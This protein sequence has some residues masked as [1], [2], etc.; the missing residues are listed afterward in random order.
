[1]G[2]SGR[3]WLRVWS[4]RAEEGERGGLRAVERAGRGRG[5]VV[6]EEG[7]ERKGAGSRV[8]PV[9]HMPPLDPEASQP[10]VHL[11]REGAGP[12]INTKGAGPPH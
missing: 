8:K 10:Q 1:M 5:G 2:G 12:P 6:W 11:R 3:G 9:G 7:R 4:G